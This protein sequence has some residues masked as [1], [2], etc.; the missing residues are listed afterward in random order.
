M[1]NKQADFWPN[2]LVTQLY[3]WIF[4]GLAC[5]LTPRSWQDEITGKK[6]A[7]QPGG[8]EED[9]SARRARTRAE[10]L[11]VEPFLWRA[12]RPETRRAWVW[13]PVAVA[14]LLWY[15]TGRVWM[16]DPF[17]PA[18]DLLVL[19]LTG[20]VLKCWLAVAA[21]RTLAEDRSTGGLELLLSTPLDEKQIVRGQRLALRRQ[22]AAPVLTLLLANGI[23]LV[24]E[25][26]KQAGEDGHILVWLHLFVG[27]FLLLDM[28]ALSWV[29][30]WL[31]LI[32]RKPNRA[33]IFAILRIL[34]L[35]CL[36][37]IVG[38]SLFAMVAPAVNVDWKGM[39]IFPG[40]LGLGTN[41][42]FSVE[43]YTKLSGQFRIVVSEGPARQRHTEPRPPAAPA[44]AE[45]E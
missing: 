1:P 35:P 26:Q 8:R 9:A 31:G 4:F 25:L 20:T 41:L 13:L 3:S 22:F 27:V 37:F 32:S 7:L 5:W 14:G 11:A 33:A 40:L 44:L 39:L 10:L 45:V 16:D 15:W 24:M 2:A 12:S 30:M 42:F 36:L 43:A 18:R 19:A 17:G 28:L 29:G 38:L 21:S 6:T 23:F 34:A